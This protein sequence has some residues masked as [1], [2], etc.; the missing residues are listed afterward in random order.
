M[1]YNIIFF[2]FREKRKINT[3][4][5]EVAIVSVSV[6]GFILQATKVIIQDLKE[7][8]TRSV[9]EKTIL[10]SYSSFLA[11]G[12]GKIDGDWGSNRPGR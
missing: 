10:P 8:N 7:G 9:Y 11:R 1:C 6:T 2:E 5:S 4:T 12:T 3:L